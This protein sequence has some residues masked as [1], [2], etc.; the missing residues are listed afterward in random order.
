ME[1]LVGNTQEKSV[2]K[3]CVTKFVQNF[4]RASI[5]DLQSPAAILLRGQIQGKRHHAMVV[6]IRV[7]GDSV[8]SARV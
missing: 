7:P 1:Q 4:F 2:A 3:T 6:N 5:A 8:A